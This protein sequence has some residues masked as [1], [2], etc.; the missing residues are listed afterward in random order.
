[1][2]TAHHLQP[3]RQ[4]VRQPL[5]RAA[6][7]SA[8]LHVL[9]L[10]T[11]VLVTTRPLPAPVEVMGLTALDEGELRD[12]LASIPRPA[13]PSMELVNEPPPRPRPPARKSEGRLIAGVGVSARPSAAPLASPPPSPRLASIG[14]SSEEDDGTAQTSPGRATGVVASPELSRFLGGLAE[15][16]RERW[17]PSQVY[18]QNRLRPL[19]GDP[20][21]TPDARALLAAAAVDARA[22]TLRI[23]LRRDG[24]L[25]QIAIAESSGSVPLDE[26]A[27]AAF[28]RAQPFT[29]PPPE[30]L[31]GA[32]TLSFHFNLRLDLSEAAYL[33]R[34]GRRFSDG[35]A[36]S[37]A[38]RRFEG[39]DRVTVVR[40]RLGANGTVS[41]ASLV[42]PSGLD[43]L[44]ASALA[45]LKTGTRLPPPPAGLVRG[46][47]VGL[48]F[49]FLHRVRNSS[50][51]RVDRDR[52]S[53]AVAD[54]QGR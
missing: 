19:T 25:G 6:A 3:G 18:F 32:G 21:D 5:R 53:A 16:V 10:G 11:L 43:L 34:L 8:G 52:G 24:S 35:W 20:A 36:P 30:L 13:P 31:D 39:F 51:V 2:A 17:H 12:L 7:T 41:E 15:R 14:I 27:T 23:E 37:P 50:V 49:T 46:G 33:A 22:T 26:E 1:M 4:R 29:P 40:A 48:R 54:N 45:A 38:V 28:E 9:G 44:D 42:A 47:Q